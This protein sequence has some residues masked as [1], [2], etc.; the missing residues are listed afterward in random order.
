MDFQYDPFNREIAINPF[1]YYEAMRADAPVH[2]WEDI[3]MW[4]VNGYD[5]V[6]RV[7]RNHKVFSSRAMAELLMGA[8]PGAAPGEKIDWMAPQKREHVNGN[9]AIADQPHH[10]TIRKIAG[11]IFMPDSINNLRPSTQAAVDAL[12]DDISTRDSFDV[13]TDFGTKL[14]VMVICRLIGIDPALQDRVRDCVDTV[15]VGLNGSKRHM[16]FVESGAAASNAELAHIMKDALKRSMTT[17][18]SEGLLGRVLKATEDGSLS[19]R[20]AGG[21]G[22]VLLFGGSETTTH[23]IGN[24]IEALQHYPHFLDE[25]LED[26]SLIP[27]MMEETVRW[28]GP[29]QYVFRTAMEDVEVGGQTIPRGAHVCVLLGSANRDERRWGEDA[30][31]YNIHRETRGHMGFAYGIHF[32]I[33]APLARMEAE[34]AL[35][36]LLPLI[37]D[38]K[39]ANTTP[40]IIDSLQ[41]RG[42]TSLAFDKQPAGAAA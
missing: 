29:V 42:Y 39:M 23:L 16:G 35:Q 34:Y 17:E 14:P 30:A 33:G 28:N 38:R 3:N 13:I 11:R 7:M 8:Y 27:N 37:K 41:F 31:E 26:P 20:E 18:E 22:N 6:S 12:I 32:C 5:D 40:E 2:Y 10:T 36:K 9:P 25:V 24:T 21:L 4:T 1:P 19:M 15:T